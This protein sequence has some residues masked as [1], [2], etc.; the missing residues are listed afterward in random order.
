MD[1]S[2]ETINNYIIMMKTINDYFAP[3]AEVVFIEHAGVLCSSIANYA[4][5]GSAGSLEEGNVYEF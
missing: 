5:V 4:E 2:N 3:S 1:K